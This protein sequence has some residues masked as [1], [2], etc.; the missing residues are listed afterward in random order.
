MS[1]V[2]QKLH[3]INWINRFVYSYLYHYQTD[4]YVVSYPKSGRTWLRTMMGFALAQHFGLE[5]E[6]YEPAHIVKKYKQ[7][8]P[9]VR[10]AH[11][12]VGYPIE[13]GR[14]FNENFQR[15]K[16][17]K[18]ILLIRDPRDVIVSYYFHRTQRLGETY[19]W[20]TFINHPDWGVRRHFYFL[21]EWERHEHIPQAFTIVRYEDLIADAKNSL[22]KI[23]D[24][25]E[26]SHISDDCL[27]TAV[28]Y[29]S[30]EKMKQRAIKQDSLSDRLRPTNA[31]NPNSHKIREGK[32]GGYKKHLTPA[33]IEQ[34]DHLINTTLS[35]RFNYSNQA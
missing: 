33:Q 34:I 35:P 18:I 32:I 17:K 28:S 9:Y 5:M 25:L 26:F 21:N 13:N 29:T 22:R 20:D 3:K 7:S 12:G 11:D 15:Y 27:E 2:K 14:F 16:N 10:F 6:S 8:A 24:F 30:F 23:F 19:S 4:G 31:S 1:L